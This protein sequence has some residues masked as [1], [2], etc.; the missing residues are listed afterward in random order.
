M[1]TCFRTRRRLGAYL[2]GALEP[3]ATRTAVAHVAGCARCQAEVDALHRLRSSLRETLS[4]ALPA[5]WTGF[6]PGVVRGIERERQAAAAPARQ[7][8][9]GRRGFRHPRV[10]FGSAL[11]AAAIGAF[12]LWQV[13]APTPAPA[14]P[15]VV[16][17]AASEHPGASV[18]V[19]S[20]PERDLAVVW[21]FDSDSE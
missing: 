18:M 11:A 7:S 16:H 19:Y 15:V 13:M 6:W 14:E 21:V 20:P 4:V 9:Q 10:A 17:A 3:G 2:D 12:T 1:L 5:D 8:W